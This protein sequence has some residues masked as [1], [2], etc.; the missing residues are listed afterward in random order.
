MKNSEPELTQL[1]LRTLEALVCDHEQQQRQQ[2][3]LFAQQQRQ[4]ENRLAALTGQVQDLQRQLQT[5][6]DIEP[7]LGARS[8]TAP[9]SPFCPFPTVTV[10]AFAEFG[11][12]FAH[13]I[14]V[15]QSC[16]ASS[17]RQGDG[18]RFKKKL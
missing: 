9:A 15:S 5:L 14:A 3:Q 11:M 12:H 6:S 2:Q 8:K 13:G 4:S 7:T 10:L 17:K 16:E 18:Q 1:L